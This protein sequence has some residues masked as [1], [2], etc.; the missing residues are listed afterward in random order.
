MEIQLAI[1]FKALSQL[2]RNC[3]YCRWYSYYGDPV[4]DD[5]SCCCYCGAGDH[6]AAAA[7]VRAAAPADTRSDVTA[8]PEN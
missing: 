8:A 3:Y 1:S 7:H 2:W 4:D 6:D 5:L